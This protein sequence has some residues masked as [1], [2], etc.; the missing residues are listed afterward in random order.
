[1]A[2]GK[3]G[4]GCKT[5]YPS[6]HPS[7]SGDPGHRKYGEVDHPP[8]VRSREVLRALRRHELDHSR[9]RLLI[10]LRDLL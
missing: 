3:E 9:P 2:R 4:F 10:N 1:M 7:I 8:I 6:I 5:I